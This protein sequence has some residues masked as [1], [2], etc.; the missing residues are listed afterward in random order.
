MSENMKEKFNPEVTANYSLQQTDILRK[1]ASLTDAMI[2]AMTKPSDD[3][4]KAVEE[5]TAELLN[6][7]SEYGMDQ[8]RF[9]FGFP[10]KNFAG[11]IAKQS[12]SAYYGGDIEAAKRGILFSAV[13][14][15]MDIFARS[16]HLIATDDDARD[17]VWNDMVKVFDDIKRKKEQAN[18]GAS[19]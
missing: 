5:T 8:A 12:M 10:L 19:A 9:I 11:T 3:A 2:E 6:G 1:A 18:E 4:A 14:G 15:Y 17:K 16:M 7:V 13:L